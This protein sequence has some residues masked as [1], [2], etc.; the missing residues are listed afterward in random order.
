MFSFRYAPDFLGYFGMN[1]V[2]L[3]VLVEA[4]QNFCTRSLDNLNKPSDEQF[5]SILWAEW[6]CGFSGSLCAAAG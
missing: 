6:P 3:F 5:Q 1:N 2:F 4:S